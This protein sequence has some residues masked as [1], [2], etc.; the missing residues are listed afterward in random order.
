MR[1]NFQL[2]LSTLALTTQLVA[3]ETHTF[4]YTAEYVTANPDGVHEKQMIGFNGKWPL[5]EIHVNKG[6]RVQL[7]LTNG[8][9]DKNT[10][11][12]FHGLFQKGSNYMDG[13][14]M[15]TQCPIAPNDTYLYNFTV[16]D[17]VGTF[18]YHSH[19]GAQY[20]D[21]L[22]APFIIH[23]V[24][25]E[26]EPYQYDEERVISIA[27]TYHKQ[28]EDV[29]KE[30][31]T[32]YNPTG[33]E[34]IPQNLLMNDTANATIHFDPNMT[35][36]LRF[37]NMGLFVSQYVYIEG[38][39]MQIVEVDGIAVEPYSVDYLYLTAGQRYSVLVKSKPNRNRN[40]AIMQKFDNT[41]L[42]VIPTDLKLETL[43]Y[44]VYNDAKPLPLAYHKDGAKSWTDF[45]LKPVG[46]I[47]ILDEPDHRIVLDV[48]MDNL[49]DGVNYAFFNNISYVPPV[50][51]S[52]IT[53]LTAGEQ[54][55]NADVYGSNTNAFVLQPD[56]VI[57]IVINNKD[58]GRH[59]FHLHGHTFQ[60]VQKS[61]A[62]PDD[63]PQSYNETDHSEF[64]KYPM[65]RDTVTLEP[66]GY[67]VLRFRADNP[68]VWIFHCHVD[69]HLEQ[70]LAVVL[71][72]DPLALQSQ[73]P[74]DDFYQ[75]CVNNG[76]PI[77][78]NAAGNSHDFLDLTGENLQPQPLPL[79]F[80]LKGYVALLVST[81][82]GLFG[83]YSIVQ[84]GLEDSIT[85]DERIQKNLLNI[86][87]ANNIIPEEADETTRL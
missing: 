7:Y 48:I 38:H 11:L 31:L 39:D 50:V 72:E 18:W 74:P 16:P 44:I 13:P 9:H 28:Y 65:I 22:R 64:P 10:S 60:I 12:H 82:V 56:D 20:A 79:G 21:G 23:G 46:D 67:V 52:L 66:N 14:Q 68:G 73:T 83:L 62:F 84:Y 37:V 76:V 1:V 81:L 33:A 43:N 32:R 6:D 2:L 58:T 70:G 51:P 85:D 59:P 71:I 8:L 75:N 30:F 55:V 77:T 53:A 57:E 27:D 3:S 4:H 42:D 49:G 54:A 19:T 69:W 26:D 61:E 15:V 36:L 34:P 86:L 29:T 80:T 87:K 78:G 17:Q 40:Y 5:P 45:D 24:D 41:M 63:E 47:E 25:E 35:Y